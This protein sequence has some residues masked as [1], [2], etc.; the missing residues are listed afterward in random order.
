LLVLEKSSWRSSPD[1][2]L[3]YIRGGMLAKLE[4]R[5]RVEFRQTHDGKHLL[6]AIHD[7]KPT[8]PWYIYRYTQA[9]LH[10]R[11]MCRFD[12]YLKIYAERKQKTKEELGAQNAL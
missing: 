3:L 7:Y 10:E 5:G 11:I 2:Q 6:C 9:L 12:R 1:R 8:L 4:G